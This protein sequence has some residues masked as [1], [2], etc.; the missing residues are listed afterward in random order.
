MTIR[1]ALVTV[2]DGVSAG[3]RVDLGGSACERELSEAGLEFTVI[4][5]D[6]L[7]DERRQ[8]TALI[9][10]KADASDADLIVLTGGTGVAPRDRTPEA[11]RAAVEFEIP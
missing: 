4:S 6:V 5:R 11:V 8:I 2:S 7:P 3:Q 9:E 1:V 10:A